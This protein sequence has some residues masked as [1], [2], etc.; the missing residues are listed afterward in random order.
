MMEIIKSVFKNAH[1]MLGRNMRYVF[2]AWSL[3]LILLL[4]GML[5]VLNAQ[6]VGLIIATISAGIVSWVAGNYILLKKTVAY[7]EEEDSDSE[8]SQQFVSEYEKIMDEA[9]SE[10]KTQFEQMEDELSRVKSIQGDA[11]AGVI[12]SFQGLE[13]QSRSQLDMVSN[14]ISLVAQSDSKDCETK[15]FRQEATAMISMFIQSIQDMSDG[16]RHMVA[17]MDTMDGNLKQIAKLLGEVDGISSQTN[18]LALNASIEAA[19]AGQA[20]RGFAVVA[21][22]VRDLSQRSHQFSS[23]IRKNYD[24][25]EKAMKDAKQ[26]VGKI[27]SS[28]LTLTMSSNERMD[29]MMAEI[30]QTNE[31]VSVELQ[32]VSNISAEITNDVEQALQSMQFEDMTNQLLVHLSKRVDTL[33]GFANASS[34]LRNDLNVVNRDELAVRHEKH[35]EHMQQVM[36]AAHELSEK[37]EK[38][39]VHQESMDD[40]EIEYF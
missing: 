21:D 18:L 26:I 35:I 34:L 4:I 32:R 19:R 24:E 25:I 23:E 37:T 10:Q 39:P 7:K 27:A 8:V 30:E 22:E 15:S 36:S 5:F 20:G 11:I 29:E 3:G 9:E 1:A 31:K 2:I 28:D 38:N 12:S 6:D 16:S 13:S 14:M 33:R 17:T 40:G